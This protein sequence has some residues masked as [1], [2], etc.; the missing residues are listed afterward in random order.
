MAKTFGIDNIGEISTD[1]LTVRR[2][3][4]LGSEVD[5]FSKIQQDERSFETQNRVEDL[6]L[7]PPITF[8]WDPGSLVDGAGET[9]SAIVYPGVVFGAFTVQVIAP[10]DLQGIICTGYVD[11]SGSCKVRLQNE[12]T[13]TI[14][15]ASGTW[16]LQA[17]RV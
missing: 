14:D 5:T 4:I 6:S 8:T 3:V 9:S 1:F 11:A 12:S 13:G 16:T 15:L 10:Y 2:R 17:R 7:L